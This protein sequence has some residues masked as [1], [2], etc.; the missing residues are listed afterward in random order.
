M[1]LLT[2]RVKVNAK[3]IIKRNVFSYY[4]T[5]YVKLEILSASITYSLVI[6]LSNKIFKK[7]IYIDI[8]VLTII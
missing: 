1:V 7:Y 3:V 6:D 2:A 4:Y 5:A 8:Y